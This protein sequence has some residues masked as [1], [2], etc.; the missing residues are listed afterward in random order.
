MAD[1]NIHKKAKDIALTATE[2]NIDDFAESIYEAAKY[3]D[4]NVFLFYDDRKTYNKVN[5]I[6]IKLKKAEKNEKE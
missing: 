6:L 2:D 4:D 5:D 1:I 3:S